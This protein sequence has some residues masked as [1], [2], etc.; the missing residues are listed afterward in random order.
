MIKNHGIPNSLIDDLTNA[1]GEFFQ[2][3]DQEKQKINMSHS[4]LAWKG[5]FPVGQE[6]TANIPDAKEGLYFGREEEALYLGGKRVP[7][8]GPNQFPDSVPQMKPL[9]LRYMIELEKL[10]QD[11]MEAFA[12]SLL[13]YK[14]KNF[15]QRLFKD[16]PT[17]LFRIF[18]YK[19]EQSAKWGVGEHSDYGFLT[20]LYQDKTGGLEVKA[21]DNRWLEVEP[22]DGAFVVN[23]GDMMELW[24]GG[25]FIATPHRVKAPIKGVKRL[26]MPFFFDPAYD[27][28]LGSIPFDQY[29]QKYQKVQLPK[30]Y[31]RW[32]GI[33]FNEKKEFPFKT[34]GEFLWH[35]VSQVFPELAESQK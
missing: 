30:G 19:Y 32:D 35:K 17:V 25:R 20:L 7:M 31:K 4:G 22:V 13:N 14:Q 2:L 26:S 16:K 34:Y 5:Y 27:A 9:L 15:F 11:L 23:I 8:T 12:T 6:L 29:S 10:S 28:V 24:S 33:E 18:N 3:P 1:G 21:L